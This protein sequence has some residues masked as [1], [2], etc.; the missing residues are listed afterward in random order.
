MKHLI[1]FIFLALTMWP[2][3]GA[4]STVVAPPIPVDRG[5]DGDFQRSKDDGVSAQKHMQRRRWKKMLRH[6]KAAWETYKSP[7]YALLQGIALAKLKQPDE[8]FRW[9]VVTKAMKPSTAINAEADRQLAEL[10][11]QLKL[12]VWE[13]KAPLAAI[14]TIDGIRV[15][16][17]VVGL[18][19]GKH[20][21]VIAEE[22][23]ETREA[24]VEMEG[25]TAPKARFSLNKVQ[26]KVEP[27]PVKAGPTAPVEEPESASIAL[28]LGLIIGGVVLAG[29]GAGLHVWGMGADSE[30]DAINGQWN[31]Q[32]FDDSREQ[33]DSLRSDGQTGTFAAY[34]LYALGGGLIVAGA[35]VWALQ[36]TTENEGTADVVLAPAIGNGGV[37]AVFSGRF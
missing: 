2:A 36:D 24:T 33:F 8:A 37:S 6:S 11:P 31:Q 29:A 17:G 20:A 12:G 35:V 4:A 25:P 23:F 21:V 3:V 16:G 14:V 15:S 9:F 34:G 5:T 28:P 13:F 1:T 32:T 27:P 19:Y 30:A 26:A 7:T 10:S 22:G 18:S